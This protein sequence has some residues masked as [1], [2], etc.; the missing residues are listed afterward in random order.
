MPKKDLFVMKKLSIFLLP[1]LLIAC[2]KT[3]TLI[4]PSDPNIAYIGRFDVTDAEKPVF[5]YSGSA[6]RTVFKGT[7]AVLILK[8][9]SLRNFFT[10]IIDDSIFVLKT[11]RPDS[12]YLLARDLKNEK[13]TLE[14][15]RRS[16][17]H[18]GNTTFLGLWIDGNGKLYKP[19]VK[20][21]KIEFIGDSYTCGYGNEG[22]SQNRKL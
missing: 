20:E 8:D 18:G 4:S 13:H 12:T 5:M 19:D 21:R 22:L 16:E 6:I 14:I 17:W 10:I 15:I 1:F 11:D 3:P 2:S 7:S 9:D